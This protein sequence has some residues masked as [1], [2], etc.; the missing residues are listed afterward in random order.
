MLFI[1]SNILCWKIYR[2]LALIFF[3]DVRLIFYFSPSQVIT[4]KLTNVDKQFLKINFGQDTAN[5][6]IR[7]TRWLLYFYQIRT[8]FGYSSCCNL[9]RIFNFTM[10]FF[11]LLVEPIFKKIEN[12]LWR[13]QPSKNNQMKKMGKRITSTMKEKKIILHDSNILYEQFHSY[14]I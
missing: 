3:A 1:Q 8:I 11:H 9:L 12:V 14:T 4:I 6:G 13:H 7:N 5:E 2:F 10:Y